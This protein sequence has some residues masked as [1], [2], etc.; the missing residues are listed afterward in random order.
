MKKGI[1]IAQY[2]P[3]TTTIN[4]TI[5]DNG[6]GIRQSFI[7]SKKYKKISDK[8]AVEKALEERGSSKNNGDNV[9]GMGL[10]YTSDFACGLLGEF[11]IFSGKVN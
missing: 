3:L 9:R 7:N 6:I 5:V 8:Q 10:N 4:A 11:Q 2:F 1:I